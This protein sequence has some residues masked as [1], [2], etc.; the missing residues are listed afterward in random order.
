MKK[1]RKIFTIR[2][3]YGFYNNTINTMGIV[4]TNRI[5]GEVAQ[6]IILSP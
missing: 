2:T 6:K 5:N 3:P 1:M 4:I